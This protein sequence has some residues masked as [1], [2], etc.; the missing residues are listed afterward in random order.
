MTHA[1]S[2]GVLDL[3]QGQ[4]FLHSA[5]AGFAGSL[6]A[7]GWRAVFGTKGASMIAFGAVSGG[8]G[9]ELAGGNFWQGAVTG[10][11]V[12]GLNHAAH[13]IDKTFIDDGNP[14]RKPI[15]KKR[16]VSKRQ[17]H[18]LSK[19]S[20]G[21]QSVIT[22]ENPTNQVGNGKGIFVPTG[23]QSMTTSGLTYYDDGTV[24]VNVTM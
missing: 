20:R 8:V 14:R 18:A 21:G 23:S 12:A 2:Q 5:V 6:G 24:D 9:S 17:A 3:M 16:L 15:G 11:I 4:D 19:G 1:V 7:S 22:P 13:E 10:G